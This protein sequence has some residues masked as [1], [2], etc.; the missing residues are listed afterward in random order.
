[1]SLQ[2]VAAFLSSLG[3]AI[4]FQAPRKDL[5]AAGL[6]GA[7]GWVIYLVGLDAGLA[8][9]PSTF[10]AA[11]V[12]GLL[13]RSS[14]LVLQDEPMVLIIPAIIPLVPGTIVYQAHLA[15][16]SGRLTE[17]LELGAQTAL[18]GAAIALGLEVAKLLVS[19]TKRNEGIGPCSNKVA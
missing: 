8:P 16:F 6:A 19:L 1:M 11:F 5:V 12:I 7:L 3:F 4:L 17:A 10:V 14:A 9:T 18:Y 2:A 13:G 15:A